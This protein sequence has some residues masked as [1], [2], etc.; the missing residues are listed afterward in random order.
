MTMVGEF[1]TSL[2]SS[3]QEIIES[4]SHELGRP[5]AIDDRHLRLLAHT[6]HSPEEVDEVRMLSVLKRTFPAKVIEW[7]ESHGVRSAGAPVVLAA[8]ESLGMDARV[9]APIR[10]H[11][12]LL[13]YLWLTDRD[14]SLT[15][16]E[17]ERAAEIAEET[18]VVL[19][20]EMLLRDLDRGRER[21]FIRDVLS[22]DLRVRHDAMA[23]LGELDL[24]VA[25][26]AV[27]VLV[28][29]LPQPN[30][31]RSSEGARMAVDVSMT[32]MRRTLG[33]KHGL[34]LLR[35]DHALLI[36][37]LA[38]PLLRCHGTVAFGERLHQELSDALGDVADARRIVAIGGTVP[39]IEHAAGSYAQALQ[40]STVAET[41]TS[42]GDVVRWDDLGIYKMLAAL[43]LDGLG[44]NIIPPNLRTLI[45][46]PRHHT[47]VRTLECYLDQAGDVQATAARLFL[48]RT[49]LYHRLHRIETLMEVDL[50][51]GDDR[52]SL[53]LGLKFARLQGFT[54]NEDGDAP[55]PGPR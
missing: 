44:A 6:E 50:K 36:V 22:H 39:G 52:L 35:P 9:C 11:G 45:A 31:G 53:H 48:H 30:D 12:H 54:W 28:A 37:S 25:R 40:A 2:S 1:D 47:L 21:E 20:R 49:S 33:P 3:L 41:L 46:E 55:A 24:F 14:G 7:V 4:A 26:G 29:T 32:R 5:V 43:P 27:A 34:H 16:A 38:D 8:N 19:Y 13:G 51:D 10:C 17:L 42:F 23:Q 15:G 18:G